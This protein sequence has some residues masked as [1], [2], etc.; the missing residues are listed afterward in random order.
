LVGGVEA[1]LRRHSGAE[2]SSHSGL[3]KM[4]EWRRKAASTPLKKSTGKWPCRWKRNSTLIALSMMCNKTNGVSALRQN[5]SN[6]IQLKYKELFECENL[7]KKTRLC[8]PLCNRKRRWLAIQ[9]KIFEKSILLKLNSLF[10]SPPSRARKKKEGG[11][12]EGK[13]SM[14][15]KTHVEKMSEN[16]LSMMLMK[17]NKLR[18]PLHD[19]DDNK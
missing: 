2:K 6:S 18:D 16:R 17:T 3:R 19:V 7:Y 12:M 15:L 1:A 11:E 13:A 4:A 9:S 8:S 5:V 14:L 10:E